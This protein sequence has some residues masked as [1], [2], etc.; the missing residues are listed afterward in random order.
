MLLTAL[1]SVK[2]EQTETFQM[3]TPSGSRV[4]VVG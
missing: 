3:D 4:V 1:N 2:S